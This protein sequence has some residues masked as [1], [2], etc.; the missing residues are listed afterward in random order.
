M[1]PTVCFIRVQ[2][3]SSGHSVYRQEI[4]TALGPAAL[5]RPVNLGRQLLAAGLHGEGN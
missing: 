2:A 4:R 3:E 1:T 5:G